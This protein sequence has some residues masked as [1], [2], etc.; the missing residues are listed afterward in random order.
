[1][2]AS[3]LLDQLKNNIDSLGQGDKM[4]GAL[5]VTILAMAI[6]FTVLVILMFVIRIMGSLLNK[7]EE[8]KIETVPAKELVTEEIVAD[9]E[10]EGELV[11][12]IAGAVA[13]ALQTGTSQIKVL[14]IVRQSSQ[15]PVWA[16]KGNV[17]SMNN[18]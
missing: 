15:A 2:N 11:A 4:F 3:Q 5:I 17:E 12:V 6:V 16:S 10:D 7:T 1:M 18:F 13:A 14:K 9:E 8:K